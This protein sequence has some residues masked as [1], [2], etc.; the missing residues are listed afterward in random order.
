MKLLLSV[1]V[2]SFA[3][4]ACVVKPPMSPQQRRALQK[5]SYEYSM[6]NVF[7]AFK[8]VLQDEGY[9]IRN[10]DYTGG[11]ILAEMQKSGSGNSGLSFLSVLGSGRNSDYATSHGYTVSVSL[12]SIN[13]RTTETRMTLEKTTRMS[14]GGQSG[15]EILDPKIYKSLYQKIDVELKRRAAQGK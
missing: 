10:Q 14:R 11:M 13:R 8:T 6:K 2:A 9:I 4:S 15:G 3:L 1:L 5:R 7:N 12:E